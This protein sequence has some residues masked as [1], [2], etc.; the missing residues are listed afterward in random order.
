MRADGSDARRI[1]SPGGYV[2]SLAWSPN[3]SVIRFSK[4][5]ILWEMAST[6]SNLHQL[7]PGWG[8][9]PSQWNGQWAQ[10]GRFYFVTDGQ[11]WSLDERHGFGKSLPAAPVQL[12]FGPT[13]WDRSVLSP[14]GKMIYASGRTNRGELVRLDQK[15][16]LLLPFL[17]GISA[18]F[19]TFS[20][21]SKSVAY[22]TYPEGLLWR[23]N[24]DG[25]SPV[26]LTD[27]PVYPKSLCWS[28]DGKQI[29]FV[30]RTALGTDAIFIIP[31]D[32]SAKPRRILPEDRM[33]ETDPNWSPDGRQVAFSTSR[34]VGA[35]SSSDLRILDLA[36]GNVAVIPASDGLLV[37]RW[38]P[39]GLSVAA[40]TLDTMSMRVFNNATGRWSN[41]GLWACC[42]SGMVAR[43]PLHLLRQV[44][45]RSRRDAYSRHKRKTGNRSRS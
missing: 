18:E 40:M 6:G 1:A 3:G 38:S 26:Q 14:N 23:A 13:V 28:P 41:A 43:Q 37:P 22:V 34:N 32:G 33:A 44:D 45:S 30:D 2:K 19:V 11:I 12:T 5:G 27:P 29:L 16:G 21:D 36:T 31:G 9:S 17:A 35:T 20:R 8:R 4:E 39:D 42:L 24:P 10:D 7:L 15:S 25:S